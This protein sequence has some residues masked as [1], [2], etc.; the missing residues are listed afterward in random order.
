MHFKAN[1]LMFVT[2]S[3]AVVYIFIAF[4]TTRKKTTCV[5]T[6]SLKSDAYKVD[7]N[8]RIEATYN[9][10][11]PTKTSTR[12][13]PG[14][15]DGD[16]GG[17]P[18][19]YQCTASDLQRRSGTILLTTTNSAYLDFTENWLESIR[20]TRACPNISVVTEDDQAFNYLS[21]KTMAG[22]NVLMTQTA[23]STTGKLVFNTKEYKKFVNKRQGY[24][25]D[26]LEQ[27]WE[28]LF[29]DVDTFWLRDPFLF[30][31]GNFDMA[32]EEDN[33]EP[34]SYCAGFVY[35]RPTERTMQFVKE[36]IRFMAND[37]TMKPDQVVMNIMI[38]R[39][40]IAGLKLRVLDSNK[41]PNGKLFFD[42]EWRKDKKDFVVVH[43][44]WIVGHDPKVERFRNCSMW[45]VDHKE[46]KSM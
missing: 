18:E 15:G 43:N 22:L 11:Q 3:L 45:L 24:I 10:F 16:G 17:S 29:S 25:L 8:L 41:F 26:L 27:G 20:R 21:N 5:D 32:L 42:D 6:P 12:L 28:V 7:T 4:S 30:F 2:Y 31:Q 37:K 23:K 34:A 44:N 39:K 9:Q 38:R 36:W 33:H 13:S 35:F 14:D 1:V 19:P 46:F 40:V